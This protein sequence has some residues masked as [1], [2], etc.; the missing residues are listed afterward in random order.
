MALPSLLTAILFTAHPALDNT[1]SSALAAA[2]SARRRRV[3]E[4]LKRIVVRTVVSIA[5]LISGGA[6]P[7]VQKALRYSW[8]T[9]T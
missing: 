4:N 5:N 9:S 8:R 3:H 1:T 6:I 7:S 2:T